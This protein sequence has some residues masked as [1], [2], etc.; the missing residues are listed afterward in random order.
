MSSKVACPPSMYL[1]GGNRCCYNGNPRSCLSIVDSQSL[2]SNGKTY[3]PLRTF[4][5]KSNV[6]CHKA[7]S[8]L[9]SKPLPTPLKMT[10]LALNPS[11]QKISEV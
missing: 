9:P 2:Y 3:P 10:R 4:A 7:G 1:E 6:C 5:K 11:S 8:A